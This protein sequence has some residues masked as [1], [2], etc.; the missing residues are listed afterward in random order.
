MTTQKED[1]ACLGRRHAYRPQA[2]W[3]VAFQPQQQFE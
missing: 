2:A 1:H 3:D